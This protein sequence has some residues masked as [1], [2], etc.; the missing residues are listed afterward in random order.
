MPDRVRAILAML[1]KTPDD[2]FLHYSLGM[3]HTSA[4]RHGEAVEQFRRCIELDAKYLAA[5]V[6]AGKALRSAGRL[7][8][9][10]ETFL[11]ALE[12][13]AAQG[14]RHTQDYIRQQL[15]ALGG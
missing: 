9:A 3:E 14:D 12:V 8:E 11:R 1:E 2:V 6:E 13:A 15:D 7:P 5:Y 4:G 10:R